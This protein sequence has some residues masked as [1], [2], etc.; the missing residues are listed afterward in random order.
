MRDMRAIRRAR[1]AHWKSCCRPGDVHL[2]QLKL[3]YKD[4]LRRY[5]S[6]PVPS[7]A[8]CREQN[9]AFAVC[10]AVDAAGTLDTEV[11]NFVSTQLPPDTNKSTTRLVRRVLLEWHKKKQDTEHVN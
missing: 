9:W 8:E 5:S 6:E 10:A 3:L 2:D 11:V 4:V 1:T 7:T